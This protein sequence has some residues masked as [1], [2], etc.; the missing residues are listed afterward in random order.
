MVINWTSVGNRTAFSNNGI[1]LMDKGRYFV[2]IRAI[3]A[4]GLTTDV[5]SDGITVDLTH[6]VF[7]GNVTVTGEN[8]I[9]NGTEC[10]YVSSVTELHVQWP[11]FSDLHSGL[12]HYEYAVIPSS[13]VVNDAD[14]K[15]VPG[16]NLHT[17]STFSGLSLDEGR[18]YIVIIRAFN[19]AGLHKDARSILI[20][21]DST[22]PEPGKVF[23]GATPNVDIEYST[24]LNSVHATWTVFSEAQSRV[25][26]YYY[27]VG[28]CQ[29]GNYH[30]TG[31]SFI[32]LSPTTA[33]KLALFDTSLINGQQY[34]VKIKAK[35][36]AGLYSSE[37]SSNGFLVDSTPPSVRK[38]IIYDG[39]DGPE[40]D[41][42][43]ST[44]RISAHWE[45]FSDPESSINYYEY[46]ISRSKDRY[47]DAAIFSNIGLNSSIDV[48]GL[49]LEEDV[50][51]VI[52]CAVNF[53]GLRMCSSSD[54]VLIDATPP[55]KGIV[56]DGKIEPDIRYQNSLSVINAN[57]EGIWDLNSQLEKFEWSIG[58]SKFDDKD[59]IQNFTD[60]GLSTHVQ[61]TK[62]LK[63]VNGRTYYV[64]LRITNKAGSVTELMSDGVTVDVTPPHPVKIFPGYSSK[65]KCGYI[66]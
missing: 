28:S 33:L 21:P 42:Q 19:R 44:T 39:F 8:G 11:G 52:V 63:L 31:N 36:L 30:V 66:F 57:W 47:S 32:E 14:F 4:A 54:G 6:P 40:R 16:H 61:S 18:P 59:S 48:T 58:T 27:A 1:S 34:C 20:V 22:P 49:S 51:Y 55:S 26:Q 65:S 46:A 17:S 23:D 60:V 38:A 37:V 53:A 29:T 64:H 13:Y 50:Y 62:R 10:Y 43:S 41:H 25:K 3:D 2:T 9:I 45:G 24:D 7:T 56:H 15:N 5:S 35:N 12:E